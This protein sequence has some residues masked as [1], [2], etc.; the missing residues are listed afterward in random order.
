MY[1]YCDIL[2]QGFTE[3]LMLL[4]SLCNKRQKVTVSPFEIF[5]NTQ[6]CESVSFVKLTSTIIADERSLQNSL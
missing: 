4:A 6:S 3:S 2:Y 1:Y 5:S